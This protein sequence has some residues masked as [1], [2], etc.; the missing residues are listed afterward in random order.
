VKAI[1]LAAGEGLRLRP[2]T[3]TIPK[4]LLKVLGEPILKRSIGGLNKHGIED[5]VII[6]N[7]LEDQIKDYVGKEFPNLNIEFIRQE[8]IKGTA[9]ALL[10]AKSKIKEDFLIAVNG[11]CIY[12]DSLIQKT[13]DAAR[14]GIISIGGKFTKEIAKYGAIITDD[15]GVPLK[16]IEK[17]SKEEI[18]EG[19]ANIGIYSLSNE[20]FSIIELMEKNISLSPRGEYEIPDAI[21][22]LL[23]MKKFDTQLVQ[24][25]KDDYWFD[26]GRPW[27]LLDANR[28][29]LSYCKDEREGLIE[30]GV[31]LKGI[32]IIKKD[33]IIRS[34]VYIEG[35]VFIDEGADIGPNCYIR[36]FSYLGKKSRIGNG[37]EI[38]NSIIEDYTHAAHLSYIGDSIIG[39]NC[40]LGAGTITANLRLDKKTIPVKIKGNKEDSERRKLGAIIGERVETGIGALLMPGIKIGSDSW[41]G[42]GTMVDEDIPSESIYFDSQKYTLRRKRKNAN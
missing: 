19:F 31:S 10:L 13:V 20:I 14:K 15:N 11:D 27:N 16:M 22:G 41:I 32:V 5:F 12:S 7:Y 37:C 17:P 39:P 18:E 24:L 1:L 34:G 30:D 25:E 3:E 6:T 35:P 2:L 21:N 23:E 9:N 40:N 29:L 33:A 26:I 4:P 8:E 28:I 36:K 38:K 42:A